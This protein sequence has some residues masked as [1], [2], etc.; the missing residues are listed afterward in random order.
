MLS[1]IVKT[2][3]SGKQSL[4]N[5]KNIIDLG[6]VNS[7][8]TDRHHVGNYMNNTN[9]S[10]KY[11]LPL[12]GSHWIFLREGKFPPLSSEWSAEIPLWSTAWLGFGIWRGTPG[13]EADVPATEL[14]LTYWISTL[15]FPL[16]SCRSRYNL[17]RIFLK[18]LF[19]ASESD[20]SGAGTR[21]S[22]FGAWATAF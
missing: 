14:P 6:L 13:D 10:C 1:V 9:F 7:S 2:K 15:S 5:F 16:H 17:S 4:F 21:V 20:S 8:C 22:K 3:G 11:F 18:G 12:S 19:F